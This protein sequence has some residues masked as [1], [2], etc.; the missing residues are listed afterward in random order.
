M[1]LS[2]FGHCFE[3]SKA[4]QKARSGRDVEASFSLF[5]IVSLILNLISASLGEN[6]HRTSPRALGQILDKPAFGPWG[7]GILPNARGKA[8]REAY[9][10]SRKTCPATYLASGRKTLL[11]LLGCASRVRFQSPRGRALPIKRHLVMRMT[12]ATGLSHGAV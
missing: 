10:D 9:C 7:P 3:A 8:K 11:M 6:K 2:W 12:G 5:C 1:P 4:E